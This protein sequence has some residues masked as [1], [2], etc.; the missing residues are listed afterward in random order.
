MTTADVESEILPPRK[1]ST[2]GAPARRTGGAGADTE[3]PP[4]PR[5][6]VK[7]RTFRGSLISSPD[8]SASKLHNVDGEILPTAKARRRPS[9]LYKISHAGGHD[10]DS[11]TSELN[12]VADG[13]TDNRL[14]LAR[15]RKSQTLGSSRT[16]ID[17]DPEIL[18]A[19]ERKSKRRTLT[20]RTRNS[21]IGAS[22]ELD[23]P[24]LPQSDDGLPRGGGRR[25]S[26]YAVR[27]T[28]TQ[29]RSAFKE[30]QSRIGETFEEDNLD[31]DVGA[32][33]GARGISESRAKR[34]WR[35]AGR[36]V[37]FGAAQAV[38]K[39]HQTIRQLQTVVHEIMQRN[40]MERLANKLLQDIEGGLDL[41]GQ[42]LPPEAMQ[43]L[44]AIICDLK[45]ANFLNVT[46]MT[47]LIIEC[48]TCTDSRESFS[49][50]QDSLIDHLSTQ[51]ET[52]M[53]GR[54]LR[55][56]QSI[57]E[58]ISKETHELRN[59]L[60]RYTAKKTGVESPAP[61][62]F[63]H[64]I[65]VTPVPAP[66]I[67][68]PTPILETLEEAKSWRRT[69]STA[70]EELDLLADLPD[71]PLFPITN[72]AD[73]TCISKRGEELDDVHSAMG[74]SQPK[75]DVSVEMIPSEPSQQPL[76]ATEGDCNASCE[77]LPLEEVQPSS[78]PKHL[79][80]SPLQQRLLRLRARSPLLVRKPM[81]PVCRSARSH[82][83]PKQ[84]VALAAL[85]AFPA[86][87]PVFQSED[88][89]H[90]ARRMKEQQKEHLEHI[91]ERCPSPSWN[92]NPSHKLSRP[93]GVQKLERQSNVATPRV[94]VSRESRQ[95]AP[96][97]E[98]AAER[99]PNRKHLYPEQSNTG[100][101]PRCPTEL[102]RLPHAC[103]QAAIETDSQGS[104]DCHQSALRPP[105]T[106]GK[107]QLG[108]PVGAPKLKPSEWRGAMS[109]L[110]TDWDTR[111]SPKDPRHS[112]TA[113]GG[114][115]QHK[116]CGIQLEPARSLSHRSD[117]C[118]LLRQSLG[119]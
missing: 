100:C 11:S 16:T 97:C 41:E 99:A 24:L 89:A 105:S 62:A 95:T 70:S 31:E 2:F 69:T 111:R 57:T 110:L 19:V 66:E 4:T 76:E 79:M 35:T 15:P 81:Q 45:A 103:K 54:E 1:S 102:M 6:K 61:E 109:R 17:A 78:E 115:P 36:A 18:P 5:R 13:E 9:Q 28:L 8:S 23:S 106:Q 10:S 119:L 75:C 83:D 49:H 22:D 113:D 118:F 82:R 107:Q 37:L 52:G 90:E 29:A 72:I 40:K 94:A 25:L 92:G 34:R 7:R 21:L 59:L 20:L 87:R 73:N 88:V 3:A 33:S 104:T 80:T 98:Q 39:R 116:S 14:A 27:R 55:N 85:A 114:M 58:R 12:T 47:S 42:A 108:D 93:S 64:A 30:L 71:S 67:P 63:A 32:G 77:L 96:A 48:A 56:L 112:L 68:E 91:I 84:L 43:A 101:S 38:R 26:L 74:P 117:A 50:L 51:A 65:E 53:N 60:K 44:R 46:D 86:I